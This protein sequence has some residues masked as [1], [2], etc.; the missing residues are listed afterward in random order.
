M[1]PV[2]WLAP[3]NQWDTT[4]VKDLLDGTLYPHGV[5]F[6][7][8]AGYPNTRGGIVLVL[9]AR[10]W[11]EHTA[12]ITAAV[13]RYRYVLAF[14]TSDEED[15]FDAAAVE[16]P[17]IRWWIQTPREGRTYPEGSRLFGVGYTPHMRQLP[18]E[19]PTKNLDVFISAQRTTT[20]RIAA[21]EALEHVPHSRVEPTAGFTQGMDPAEYVDCMSKARVAPAPSG[22]VSPDSFR[23]WEALEAHAIPLPDVVS[24]IDGETDYWELIGWPSVRI[25]DWADAPGWIDHYLESWPETANHTV[26]WWMRYKRQL[27]HW[28]R[29]DLETLGAL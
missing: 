4:L 12:E 26:A 24:P 14:R 17:N 20:R 9:P 29:E 6:K 5:E 16:H 23:F 7:H 18:T 11:W 10:Y 13:R 1:I 19:P 8:H 25:K 27:S 15:L 2:G 3:G 28:L 22:A 21:F